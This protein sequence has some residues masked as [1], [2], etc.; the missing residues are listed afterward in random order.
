[1]ILY[2]IRN[3]NRKSKPTAPNANKPQESNLQ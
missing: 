2:K 1:M 3:L